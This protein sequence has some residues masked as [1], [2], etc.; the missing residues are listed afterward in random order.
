MLK[1]KVG[2]AGRTEMLKVERGLGSP[3][4]TLRSRMANA[5]AESGNGTTD[6]QTADH[7]ENQKLGKQKA[8]SRKRKAD[9]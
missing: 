9:A 4:S 1:A 8:E 5:E 7:M 6:H 2:A 3:R